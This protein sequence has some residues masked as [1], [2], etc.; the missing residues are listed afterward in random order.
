MGSTMNQVIIPVIA[1]TIASIVN[2]LFGLLVLRGSRQAMSIRID[3]F[4]LCFACSIWATTNAVYLLAPYNLSIL[5]ASISYGAAVLIGLQFFF[6]CAHLTGVRLSHQLRIIAST[7]AVVI[8]VLVSIPGVVV[9]GVNPANY[10]LIT[11]AVPLAL[12]GS[13]L[14]IYMLA[15]FVLLFRGIRKG[16]KT[17]RRR[18][19][20]LVWGLAAAAVV[21]VGCNLLLPMLGEYAY[22]S[23]GPTASLFF[24]VGMAYTMIRHRVFDVQAAVARSVAYTMILAAFGGLFYALAF[25]VSWLVSKIGLPE[26]TIFW[27]NAAIA[28]LM[29][30][31]YQPLKRFFDRVTNSIFFRDRYS[32]EELYAE[33]NSVLVGTTRLERLLRESARVIAD[34]LSA[35]GVTFAIRDQVTVISVGINTPGKIAPADLQAFDLWRSDDL[36]KRQSAIV[37]DLLPNTPANNMIRRI[38]R[39][40][41]AQIVLPL[42]R[43]KET[44]G[45]LMV[46]ERRSGA[47]ASRDVIVLET[48]A[49]ELTIAI[50]NALS[51][52]EVQLLNDTLQQKID[53]AT[54]ELRASNA[55]LRRLDEVKDEFISMASH[56][57]R[58][59][60][61]SVKGYIDMVLE[62]DAGEVSPMQ[63]RF[64]SEAFVSSE[65]MVHLINDFL[66]VSRL[67]TGKFVVEKRP[68]NL[69]KIVL[70]ELESLHVNAEGRSLAFRFS[71]KGRLPDLMLDEAKIRQVV[72]NF[73][74]NALYYS[75]PDTTIE[76]A[77][78]TDAK[79]VTFTV[80]DTGIG[81]PEEEQDHLFTKFY[82]ASNA[83]KQRPDGTGVGLYL[84]K[85][86]VTA[87]GGKIIFK[88]KENT[89]STFGFSLPLERLRVD[90]K[91]NK[92]DK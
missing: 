61:T 27:V 11:H 42:L 55:Q 67:Q 65:R 34:T 43:G 48:I 30:V 84:A 81:V 26:E 23:L 19:Y 28:L 71:S 44:I 69:K 57:L 86:V 80:K 29:A 45:Y 52:R 38:M 24:V 92:L 5:A 87:H 16:T 72:M 25:G 17:L 70:E 46:G 36:S 79:E 18:L 89:G 33:L 83:R 74:D 54:K 14:L 90:D 37:R 3:F 40:Y 68:N 22:V 47:Y 75:K 7:L 76:V 66:N 21:G 10:A 82:R 73:A 91:S 58:T 60:L 53:E 63:R 20:V 2:L 41:K 77:L 4:I 85:R 1:L 15:G 59:P 31:M 88:S 6:M 8:M 56:Q 49:N 13:L 35:H 64:L 32:R 12:F 9:Y 50:Q 51:I 62:G 39:S 78:V